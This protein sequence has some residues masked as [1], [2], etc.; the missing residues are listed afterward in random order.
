LYECGNDGQVHVFEIKMYI[1]VVFKL[2]VWR[3]AEGYVFGLQD[4]AL[5][6]LFCGMYGVGDLRSVE[7]EGSGHLGIVR[8]SVCLL[9]GGTA[10][11]TNFI[12]TIFQSEYPKQ[13]GLL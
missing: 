1:H 8:E 6:A 7:K 2:L 12:G 13:K 5:L 11:G 10:C 9:S 4:A 3:E